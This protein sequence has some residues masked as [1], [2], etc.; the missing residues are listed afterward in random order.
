MESGQGPNSDPSAA[1][2]PP[3]NPE[4]RVAPGYQSAVLVAVAFQSNTFAPNPS[5]TNR[6]LPV[7]TPPPNT[8]SISNYNENTWLAIVSQ[9]SHAGGTMVWPFLLLV[10]FMVMLFG[11]LE[12]RRRLLARGKAMRRLRNEHLSSIQRASR[13]H[14]D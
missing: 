5:P 4:T 13:L 2:R 7:P 8:G 9:Q 11:S 3:K 6:P 1:A 14:I 12:I 10:L